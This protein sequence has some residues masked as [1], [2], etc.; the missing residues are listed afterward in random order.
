[1]LIDP[2][3]RD[4]VSDPDPGMFDRCKELLGDQVT[5]G[6]L[7]S[8]IEVSTRPFSSL[9]ALGEDLR[10]LRRTVVGAAREHGMGVI[11]SS[12]HPFCPVVETAGGAR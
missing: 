12:T 4:L 3:T 1:M 7:R 2:G 5:H 11:A 6:L 9:A 8:Q 10:Y